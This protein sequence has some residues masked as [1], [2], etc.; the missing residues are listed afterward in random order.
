MKSS[1]SLQSRS[2]YA[3]LLALSLGL[4][5]ATVPPVVGEEEEERPRPLKRVEVEEEAVPATPPKKIMVDDEPP[6]A[7]PEMQPEAPAEEVAPAKS[8]VMDRSAE[9]AKM[10][11]TA[12]FPAIRDY[13][14]KFVVAHD[15][16]FE[17]GGKITRITPV[18]YLWGRI[19]FPSGF[20][21][22]ELDD[23][24]NPQEPRATVPRAVRGVVPFERYAVSETDKFLAP[25]PA[26][27]PATPAPPP[28]AE[29][30]AAAEAVLARVLFFHDRARDQNTRRGKPWDDV[31]TELYGKLTEVRVERVRQAG[32]D[33]DW[34]KLKELSTRLIQLYKSNLTVQEQVYGAQLM[35]AVELAR[36]K[37]VTDLERAR[38]LLSEYEA[39]FPV[40]RSETAQKVR[41]HLG[42]QAKTFLA[43]ATSLSNQGDKS[44]A[45]NLLKTVEAIDPDNAALR[46]LQQDLKTGYPIL[47]VGVRRLPDRMSPARARFDSEKQAAQLMFE[48][49][50]AAVP[51]ELVG[52]RYE[53][54]LAADRP[55]V[56]AGVRDVS[57]VRSADWNDAEAG[58]F[59]AAD[60]TAT[61]NLLRQASGSW[62][63]EPIAW[64]DEPRMDP[65][66]P[67][68]VRLRFKVGHPDPRSLLTLPIHPGR[69][70]LQQNRRI[71]DLEFARRPFGTGPFRLAANY[72]PRGANDPPRDVVFVSNP[73]YGRRPGRTGQPFIKEVR[74]RDISTVPDLAAEF[75]ADRIQVV[76]DVPTADLPKYQAN[77]G[78]GN[79]VRV[80]TPGVNRQIHI[81]AI[82][83][84]RP[85]LANVDV[86]RG[87]AHAIDRTRILNEVYRAGNEEFHAPL[88]GP[89]PAGS[90]ATPPGGP[91]DGLFSR[92]QAQARL[93]AYLARPEAAMQL[94]LLY[95]DDDLRAKSA[96]ERIKQMVA[97]AVAHEERKLEIVP[98]PTRP[99][100]LL[101]LVE[102]EHRYDLAYLP[103]DYPGDWYPLELA[104]FLDPTA[105]GADGRN[106]TGYLAI[107]SHIK[108]EDDQL[109][110][111]L[112]ATR[113]YRDPL[114]KLQPLAHDLHRRFN[115]AVPFVPLWQIDRHM[116][117]STNLKVW[118][119][120]KVEEA[121][122]RLLNPTVPFT[123]L[124]RWRLE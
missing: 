77:N 102:E 1:S 39:R 115:D 72:Q 118:L 91:P 70:L 2:R 14:A 120:G 53:P 90:W 113:L 40:T 20:G 12:R 122:P 23:T 27:T 54:A 107:K 46:K 22:A 75:R 28:A 86:R 47:V 88:T 76:T 66:D 5:A 98:K 45:Q 3:A 36:S 43:D 78:L 110:R 69:W 109:S 82:N 25:L 17:A 121:S 9:L 80:V 15:R 60:V 65:S 41:Q 19:K 57:L 67:G 119:A 81:L 100:D 38:T 10:S 89:F 37:K 101:R 18:P 61:L 30:L 104:S 50:L 79:R 21:V 112:Q 35:E 34:A 56:G 116:V 29:K 49:L 51:D 32:L 74:F 106:Y 123:S 97:A 83:H 103:F 44:R 95:P 26:G 117:M 63:A 93:H 13:A 68:F 108:E 84:R 7:A 33:R 99:R 52:V 94:E 42:E 59:D 62:T 24:G 71:D 92:D 55:L 114:G 105:A 16:L 64:L 6:P 73:A 8:V 58:R 48:G 85:H 4:A 87:L 11:A 124:G 111:L 96:C 31:K